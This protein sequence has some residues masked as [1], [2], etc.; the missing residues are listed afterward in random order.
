MTQQVEVQ[1]TMTYISQKPCGCLMMAIIDNPKHK[2]E[3]AKEV[4]KA[5]RLGE[6]VTRV[7]TESVKTM[8]W[9]CAEHKE[10]S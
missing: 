1:A 2:K 10:V 3:V 5:I 8:D 7:D 9:K 6:T 4:A